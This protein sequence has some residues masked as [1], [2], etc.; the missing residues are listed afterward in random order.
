MKTKKTAY[1]YLLWMLLFTIVP[2]A[3][4]CYYAFTDENGN[5]TSPFK[6]YSIGTKQ[7]GNYRFKGKM[8]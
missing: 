4:V 1:P 6:L 2:I 8:V 7:Y 3:M 5:F